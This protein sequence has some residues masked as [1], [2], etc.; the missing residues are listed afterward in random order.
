MFASPNKTTPDAAEPPMGS[1]LPPRPIKLPEI[2][3]ALPDTRIISLLDEFRPNA[4]PLTWLLV[5]PISIE[6]KLLAAI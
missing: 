3:F 4:I 1:P 5:P 6:V 2:M